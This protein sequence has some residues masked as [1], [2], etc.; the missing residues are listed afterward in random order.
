MID[1]HGNAVALTSTVNTYFG[2]KGISFLI[3]GGG[4]L[5][6]FILPV[7]GPSSG[8]LFNNQM[9]DF[10]IPG[11]ASNYFGLA[12]SPLNYP[13]PGKRPLSSMSPSFVLDSNG[14]I[15]LIGNPHYP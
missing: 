4:I 9:D 14:R 11:G 12:T 13:Q 7:I 15:R 2:S 5:I 8:V 10:S 1:R 3:A 6:H